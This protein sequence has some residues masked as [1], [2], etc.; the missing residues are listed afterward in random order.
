MRVPEE[1]PSRRGSDPPAIQNPAYRPT[2][3]STVVNSTPAGIRRGFLRF[4]CS[5]TDVR[6]APVLE[7]HTGCLTGANSRSVSGSGS[8]SRIVQAQATVVSTGMLP[9]VACE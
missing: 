9:F 2:G 3:T 4:R 8:L 1:W 7:S 5:R 6:S